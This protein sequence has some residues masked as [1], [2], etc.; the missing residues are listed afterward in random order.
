MILFLCPQGQI[1]AK[2][3]VAYS[4]NERRKGITL[5]F[6]NNF[7]LRTRNKSIAKRC[8]FLYIPC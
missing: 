7:V 4:Y 1:A 6:L 2:N 5:T 8:S 3:V